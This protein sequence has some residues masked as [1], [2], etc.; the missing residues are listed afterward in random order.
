MSKVCQAR[1]LA[2]TR[3]LNIPVLC[4]AWMKQNKGIVHLILYYENIFAHNVV[5]TKI[6]F[7]HTLCPFHSGPFWEGV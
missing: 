7:P 1:R 5:H 3:K 2:L 4:I 6:I